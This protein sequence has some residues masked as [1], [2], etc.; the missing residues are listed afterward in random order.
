MTWCS[1]PAAAACGS[2]SGSGAASVELQ[3]AARTREEVDFRVTGAP[4]RIARLLVA[5]GIWR[6]LGPRVA[7][8]RG[9]RDGL[10]A[11]QALLALPLDL[12]W[13][14]RRRR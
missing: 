2:R 4:A 10:A 1:G 12:G 13:L 6:R 11:L 14:A 5:H 7:R 8:V 3:G 9:R